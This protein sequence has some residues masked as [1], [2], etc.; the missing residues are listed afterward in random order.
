M[1]LKNFTLL[2]VEDEQ[3][4]IDLMV[5]ILKDEVKELYIAKDGNEGIKKYLAYNPDLVLTDI[6]MPNKNGID[7]SR[8][9]KKMDPTQQIAVLTAF[10]ENDLL[11]EAINIGIDRYILKPV[12]NIDTVFDALEA[13]AT[14]L[15]NRIDLKRQ[16]ALLI[17]QNRIAAMA[18]MISH[19]AHQWRQPIATISMCSNNILADINLNQVEMENISQYATDIN[20]QT[21]HLSRTIELFRGFLKH[22]NEEVHEFNIKDTIQRVA[23]LFEHTFKSDNIQVFSDCEDCKVVLKEKQLEQ[24]LINIF[25]N[26]RDAIVQHGDISKDRLFFIRTEHNDQKTKIMLTFKDSGGGIE[27]NLINRIFEPYFTTK[28]EYFDTGLGLFISHYIVT[29]EFKG[30]IEAKTVE[31]E[32]NGETIKGAQFSIN[33]PLHP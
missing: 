15:Q 9:I 19:I 18:E 17:Y 20:M 6:Y 13:L 10:N 1:N 21:Q 23:T 31:Y 7:M 5:E 12:T 24:A 11:K 14:I 3:N 28:H 25:N 22:S 8:Q 26:A 29:K 16:E 30:Q 27:A 33:I 4:S 32:Y 2:Y